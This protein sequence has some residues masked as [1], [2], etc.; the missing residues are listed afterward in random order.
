MDSVREILGTEME[1]DEGVPSFSHTQ[2]APMEAPE[3]VGSRNWEKSVFFYF[4]GIIL[5]DNK[6]PK[7]FKFRNVC[8]IK[9]LLC[10][11]IATVEISSA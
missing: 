5:F 6:T 4:N 3:E 7:I 8:G 1:A 11:E 10:L 2:G 9:I